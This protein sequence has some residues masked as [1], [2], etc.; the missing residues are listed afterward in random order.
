MK[1]ILITGA[2]ILG[3][4][5]LGSPTFAG[6]YVVNG[7]PASPAEMQLLASYG[8][9]PGN[10]VVDGYGISPAVQKAVVHTDSR[11]GKCFYVLDV[12]LCD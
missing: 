9:Q 3:L 6:G 5:P 4:G 10:W 2:A 1:R 12:Q 11:T 7:H 8:A